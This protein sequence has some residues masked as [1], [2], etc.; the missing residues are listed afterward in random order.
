VS[1]TTRPRALIVDDSADNADMLAM[2]LRIWGYQVKVCYGGVSALEVAL[3][4]RP[5]VVLLDVG[6]PGMNGF[7]VASGLREMPGLE[8][9]I[10]IGISGHA[11]ED[12]RSRA[13]AMG[14]NHYLIKPEDPVHLQGL[15]AQA[16]R[17][18]ACRV[19]RRI[20][21]FRQ[22]SLLQLQEQ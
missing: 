17:I 18:V 22:E 11:G 7:Q 4:F 8:E 5:Q 19:E 14:M 1:S 9:T 12:C 10:I 3:T 16:L 6:M 15:L 20:G 2:L 21:A 13:R